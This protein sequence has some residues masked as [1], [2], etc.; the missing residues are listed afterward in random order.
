MIIT[1][2]EYLKQKCEPCSSVEEG[3]EIAAK[4]LNELSKSGS[5]IGLAANQIGI[6]KRVC[7]INVPTN[8]NKEPIIL[9]NP[10]VIEKSE[11]KFAF[12]EGCLSFPNQ[13][14]TTQR[15]KSIMI[16][17]DN[18]TSKLYFSVYHDNSEEGYDKGKYLN[19]AYE[20][21]CVQHELDHLD[22]ITMFER[23]LEKVTLQRKNPK[24]G[25]N[26][27]VLIKKGSETKTIKYKKFEKMSEDGWVL[28][29]V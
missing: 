27:K 13:Q 2:K 21:A 5:G 4:L 8:N 7:V 6:N 16:K 20:T 19:Y 24:V 12:I 10:E 1:D 18:H 25:R 23:K 17:A 14:V 3:E 26:T 22:G 11:D 9:I 29:E 28:V 15:Y